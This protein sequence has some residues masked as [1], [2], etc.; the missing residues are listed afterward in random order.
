[1]KDYCGYDG[2]GDFYKVKKQNNSDEWLSECNQGKN[3]VCSNQQL[4]KSKEIYYSLFLYL[5][6]VI[7]LVAALTVF[8]LQRTVL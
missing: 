6:L 5:C 4:K 7:L 1:M 2:N 3:C 8:L